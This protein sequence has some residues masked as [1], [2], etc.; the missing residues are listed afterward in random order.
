[1]GEFGSTKHGRKSASY[2]TIL[3]CTVLLGKIRQYE[4]VI[5]MEGMVAWSEWSAGGNGRP[6]GMVA[7]GNYTV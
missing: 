3:L 5:V 6:E 1:M 2:K 4:F 7:Q